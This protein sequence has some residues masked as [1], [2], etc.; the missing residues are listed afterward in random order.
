MSFHYVITQHKYAFIKFHLRLTE[1]DLGKTAFINK[2]TAIYKEKSVVTA[3]H[4]ERTKKTFNSVSL[5]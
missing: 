1:K 2:G 4:G 5:N 3:S